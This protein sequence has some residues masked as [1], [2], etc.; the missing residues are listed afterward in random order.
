MSLLY[1]V[2]ELKSTHL[3]NILEAAENG[4]TKAS[5]TL[6]EKLLPKEFAPRQK[7]ETSPVESAPSALE[8]E[9]K[10]LKAKQDLEELRR[11][12]KEDQGGADKVAGSQ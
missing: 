8:C 3:K 12:R 7:L 1:A 10:A 9:N 5:I 6:L 2:A 11:K 4:S